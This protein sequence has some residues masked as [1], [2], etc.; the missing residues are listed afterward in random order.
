M[1]QKALVG[2]QADGTLCL[3]SCRQPTGKHRC[4]WNSRLILFLNSGWITFNCLGSKFYD[5]C[6]ILKCLKRNIS[7]L[8][9]C[10]Q[11]TCKN[12][13][14]AIIRSELPF[15][16]LRWCLLL[17][18]CSSASSGKIMWYSHWSSPGKA[19]DQKPLAN[20]LPTLLFLFQDA[21]WGS[22][23]A[24]LYILYPVAFG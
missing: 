5:P 6:E 13:H 12:V 24:G 22:V 4:S 2:R 14:F 1:N 8:L 16:F 9:S 21:W 20:M 7:S 19:S 18:P 3:S 10:L 15:W 23:S 17:L 11:V